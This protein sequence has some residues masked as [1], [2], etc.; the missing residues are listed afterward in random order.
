MTGASIGCGARPN[1]G[2]LTSH[3]AGTDVLHPSKIL[4][5]RLPRPFPSISPLCRRRP[6]GRFGERLPLG[7]ITKLAKLRAQERRAAAAAK[8]TRPG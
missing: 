7:L 4:L 5:W 6:G 8:R 3:R 2:L 1:D